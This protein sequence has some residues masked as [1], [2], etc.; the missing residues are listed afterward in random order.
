[1]QALACAK[2]KKLYTIAR[3]KSVFK[4][5]EMSAANAK[6]KNRNQPHN[7]S[8]MPKILQW[9]TDWVLIWRWFRSQQKFITVTMWTENSKNFILFSPSA[10]HKSRQMRRGPIT[11]TSCFTCVQIGGCR[12]PHF[13]IFL[14]PLPLAVVC[15]TRLWVCFAAWTG[16]FYDFLISTLF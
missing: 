11:L 12:V 10:Y 15:V 4:W 5:N 2:R 14:I 1:M 3:R 8:M 9:K 7:K 16:D 6:K 13:P